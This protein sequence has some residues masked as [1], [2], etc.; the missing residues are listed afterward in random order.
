VFWASARWIAIYLAGIV[1]VFGW[2]ISRVVAD[3]V[4][5]ENFALVVVLPLAWTIS[6]PGMAASL[7]LAQRIRGLQRVLTELAAR[8]QGGAP[9]EEQEREL[10]DTFTALAAQENGLPERLVRPFVRRALSELM[11]RA[12]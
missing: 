9:T 8:V 7:I 3:T 5:R 2:S 12:R 6:F 1:L 11:Q 4:T 10:V